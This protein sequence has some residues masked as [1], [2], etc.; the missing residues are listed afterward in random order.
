MHKS[1]VYFII[2]KEKIDSTFPVALTSTGPHS[3]LIWLSAQLWE[4]GKGAEHGQR[5]CC[6]KEIT[7][8]ALLR[9][10][11]KMGFPL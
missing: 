10:L 6:E 11:L 1:K 8:E 9:R 7:P 4:E 3:L 2:L 5:H